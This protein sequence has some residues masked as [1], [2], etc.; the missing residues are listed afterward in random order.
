MR[1]TLPARALAGWQRPALRQINESYSHL[2]T[3]ISQ[4][5]DRLKQLTTNFM[6]TSNDPGREEDFQ[7]LNQQ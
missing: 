5:G 1:L 2:V 3:E 6:L 7:A 4:S